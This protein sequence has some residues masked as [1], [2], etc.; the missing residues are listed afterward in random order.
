M[1]QSTFYNIRFKHAYTTKGT[2]PDVSFGTFHEIPAVLLS[3]MKVSFHFIALIELT[4]ED[5]GYQCFLLSSIGPCT[6]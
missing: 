6:Q 1:V 5:V 2:V 4:S 3:F